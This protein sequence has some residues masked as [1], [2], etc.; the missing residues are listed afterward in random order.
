ML[1]YGCL[2]KITPV[3]I[4]ALME[5]RFTRPHS[6]LKSCDQP[7]RQGESVFLRDNPK[8]VKVEIDY[9]TRSETLRRKQEVIRRVQDKKSCLPLRV[10]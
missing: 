9:E 6:S 1:E 7:L 3:N 10:E 2:H 8:L 4:P 5:G